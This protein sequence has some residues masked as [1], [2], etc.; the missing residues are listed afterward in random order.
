MGIVTNPENEHCGTSKVT[1]ARNAV[2]IATKLIQSQVVETGN[3]DNSA[4]LSLVDAMEACFRSVCQ[5][6]RDRLQVS[7]HASIDNQPPVELSELDWFAKMAYNSAI[8]CIKLG[9]MPRAYALFSHSQFLFERCNNCAKVQETH[10]LAVAALLEDGWQSSDKSKRHTIGTKALQIL[11][12][13]N[14]SAK[15]A[16]QSTLS[17][18]K[19]KALLFQQSS[20][21]HQQAHDFIVEILNEPFCTPRYLSTAASLCYELNALEPCR[22]ALFQSIEKSMSLPAVD[23]TAVVQQS[24]QLLSIT[25][26]QDKFKIYMVLRE[27]LEGKS[28]H[29]DAIMK[30]YT[31]GAEANWLIID[32]WNNGVRLFQNKR[33]AEASKFLGVSMLFHR[34]LR[35]DSEST[36][37]KKMSDGYNYIKDQLPTA[38]AT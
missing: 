38:V 4:V 30:T 17:M 11:Q 26:G 5:F 1:V 20:E 12:Q 34:I 28:R 33:Y 35:D 3:E 22:V 13:F 32:A 10:T 37:Y 14:Q 23:A 6:V 18:L 15:Q 25:S 27:C 8:T 9:D 7:D 31:D 21:G 2:I 24:R 36:A 19:L 16:P 29:K